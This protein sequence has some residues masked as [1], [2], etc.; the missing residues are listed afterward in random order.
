M[1]IHGSVFDDL[2]ETGSREQ[3]TRQSAGLLRIRMDHGPVNARLGTMVAY[4]GD[5]RLHPGPGGSDR[6]VRSALA[7]EGPLLGGG[8]GEMVQLALRG[9]GHVL[10][11]P[12][13]DRFTGAGEQPGRG[14]PG[15]LFE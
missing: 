14:G 3:F 1:A 12:T 2:R 4:Q 7:G 11:Q 8:A 9:N 15:A 6:L 13:R 5:V 10:V